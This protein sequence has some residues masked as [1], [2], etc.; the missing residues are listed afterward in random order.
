MVKHKK[1]KSAKSPDFSTLKTPRSKDPQYRGTP[2]VWR[3]SHRDSD[4][5]F[6]WNEIEHS[7]LADIVRCL[8]A[9]ETMQEHEIRNQGSHPIPIADL[10]KE[11]RDRL[12]HKQL[13]DL[14]CIHSFRT[15]GAPRFHCYQ[16][17]GTGAMRLLWWDPDHQVCPAALK[18]T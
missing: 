14:D 2:L 9:F 11:A 5:P 16:L 8:A 7:D 17:A 15:G 4:G 1:P 12:Q 18:H 10:S 3:F 13:D 6:S